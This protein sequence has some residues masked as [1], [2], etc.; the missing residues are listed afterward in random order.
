MPAGLVGSKAVKLVLMGDTVE[1][2]KQLAVSGGAGGCHISAAV[3][4]RLRGLSDDMQVAAAAAMPW[5]LQH[6]PGSSGMQHTYLLWGSG[7]AVPPSTEPQQRRSTLLSGL[8]G[9]QQQQDTA[10]GGKAAVAAGDVE[11]AAAAAA[12]VF[13]VSS[14]STAAGTAIGVAAH[15]VSTGRLS[16]FLRMGSKAAAP[17]AADGST[18][19]AAAA[20]PGGAATPSTPSTSSAAAGSL[21][22]AAAASSP[23]VTAAL[24]V[25]PPVSGG[26]SGFM[27]AAKRSNSGSSWGSLPVTSSRDARG[28]MGS[29]SSTAAAAGV[30]TSGLVDQE[31]SA[32][33]WLL[34]S[35]GDLF[36]GWASRSCLLSYLACLHTL[37]SAHLVLDSC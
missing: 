15:E 1:V 20:D 10:A 35:F 19:P 13:G 23:L 36:K 28:L 37:A 6:L 21:A 26:S 5:T 3:Y 18:T 32:D 9:E 30:M 27:A 22:A 14:S 29:S 12:S 2:A 4:E 16:R 8:Q 11:V 17:A 24:P 31:V 25:P 7:C 33:S 34:V